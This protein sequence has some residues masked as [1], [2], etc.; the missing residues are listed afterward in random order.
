MI[1]KKMNKIKYILILFVLLLLNG[2]YSLSITTF[3]TPYGYK[4]QIE[5]QKR[6]NKQKRHIK[7][8]HRKQRR[9]VKK[10]QNKRIIL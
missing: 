2:C 6:I 10:L 4:A 7:R 8:E 9:Y 5:A 3:P 1:L